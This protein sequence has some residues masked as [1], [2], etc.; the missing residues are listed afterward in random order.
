MVYMEK[1][2]RKN[3]QNFTTMLAADQTRV[4]VLNR[5]IQVNNNRIEGFKKASEQTDITVLKILFSRLQITSVECREE[6]S[7][8]VYKL[9]GIP[10]TKTG[11]HADFPKAWNEITNALEKKDHKAILDAC[12][13]EEFMTIKSYEYALRYYDPYLTTQHNRLF[14]K[15]KEQ[16]NEDHKK[17]KNLREILLKQ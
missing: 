16:L 2:D 9:G 1:N 7:K 12:Y 13:L 15:Q 5:Q 3:E 8:E 14:I 6:L 17:V 4:S 11:H 10:E